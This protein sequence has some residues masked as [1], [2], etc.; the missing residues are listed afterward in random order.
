MI[1][2]ANKGNSRH[3]KSL[4]SPE[5]FSIHRKAGGRYVVKP[6]PGR[7]SVEKSVA[8]SLFVK[9][10]GVARTTSEATAVIRGGGVIVNGKAI[11][12]AKYPVG[13]NDHIALV[14]DNKLYEAG[15]NGRG[16][17]SFKEV[18]ESAPTQQYKVVGKYK[19]KKDTMMIR[20]HDGRS[21]KS[22][23]K[24]DRNDSVV[25]DK[26]MAVK[27][28]LKMKENAKCIIIDGVHVGAE[29]K[30]VE[31]REGNMH[32]GAAALIESS[33]GERF[34]TLVRNLMVIG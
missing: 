12:E 26:S 7:H 1:D 24:I 4:A 14:A 29:G 20:L 5:Y 23:G 3:I 15:I 16:Q 17:L 27:G 13:M 6:V 34:E 2:M 25:L 9:K 28:V 22:D 33:H 18:K 21:M 10:L 8:L 30:V 19:G 31:I 11:K 32:K